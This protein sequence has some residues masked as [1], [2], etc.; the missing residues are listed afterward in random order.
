[1]DENKTK[2]RRVLELILLATIVV[3]VALVLVELAGN[4]RG[5]VRGAL[6]SLMRRA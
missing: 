4:V 3:C 6:E 5:E 1:M 2:T